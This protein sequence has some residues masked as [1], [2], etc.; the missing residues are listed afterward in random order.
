MANAFFVQHAGKLKPW[1][2]L[3]RVSSRKK[4]PCLGCDN[5]KV[6]LIKVTESGNEKWSCETEWVPYQDGDFQSR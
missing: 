4:C 3:I 5:S 6:Y 1:A 2:T